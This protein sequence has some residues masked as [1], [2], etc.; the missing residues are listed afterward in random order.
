MKLSYTVPYNQESDGDATPAPLSFQSNSTG[1]MFNPT[2][3]GSLVDFYGPEI[4]SQIVALEE[5][6]N[7]L[8]DLAAAGSASPEVLEEL[9]QLQAR[10]AAIEA[11]A[12]AATDDAA[13]AAEPLPADVAAS[14]EAAGNGWADAVAGAYVEA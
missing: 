8:L 10:L 1:P 13:T 2:A 11:D 6:E 9:A 12:R 3:F 14:I 5:R 7:D 4:A